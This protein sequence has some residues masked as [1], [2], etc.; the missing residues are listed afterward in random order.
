[1]SAFELSELDRQRRQANKLYL[2]FLR[3]PGLSLGLYVLPRGGTDAQQPHGEDE[4]YH[5]IRGRGRFRL[6]ADDRAVQPGSNLFAPAGEPYR[7]H[8]VTDEMHIVVF[9]APAEGT[10]QATAPR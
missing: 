2:E 10:A 3:V 6:G 7:F 8:S 9:F 5:V 1:M 4:V